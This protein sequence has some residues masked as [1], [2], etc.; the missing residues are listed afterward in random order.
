MKKLSA[1]FKLIRWKNLVIIALTQYLIK[2]TLLI[3]FITVLSLN[4]IEFMLLVTSTI[5]IAA[6]GYIINDYFDTQVDQF[7]KREIIVGNT[8][9]RRS[10]ILLHITFSIIGIVIGFYLAVK[11]NNW[12][13]G[14]INVLSVIGLW[15]YSTYFKKNYLIGNI[16][17]SILS[18][19]A[20]LIVA[21]YEILPNTSLNSLNSLLTFKII[22]IY[23]GFAFITSFIREIIKDLEDLNGDKRMGYKTYAIIHGRKKTKKII[24]ILNLLIISSVTYVLYV[25]LQTNIYAFFYVLIFVQSPLIYSSF[26][27]YNANSTVDF[28]F[29]SNLMKLIMLTG[30]ST[31]LVFYLLIQI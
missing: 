17:I 22:C 15:F 16:L 20:L 9:K 25:Q 27:I 26:K 2:Y 8:I 23:S 29:I 13:Y 5:L 10:A 28:R 14:C 7:N 6:A 19:L 30:I 21:I 24:Q 4:S 1:F 11:V 3:P 12:N 18:A 31:M